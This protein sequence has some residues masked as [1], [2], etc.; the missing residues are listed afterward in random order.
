MFIP[1]GDVN[2]TRTRPFVNYAL[3]GINIAV[4]LALCFPEPSDNVLLKYA[5]IPQL[6]DPKTF[7]TSMFLHANLLHLIGNMLFLWIFGDNIEDQLG[8]VAYLLIYVAFGLAASFAHI[9]TTTDPNV[10]TLG[11]SGAISGVIGAY[12]VFFPSHKI[13]MLMLFYYFV[14]VF[15]VAA[16]WWIGFWIIEQVIFQ[17]MGMP[18]VAYMAHIGGCVA[19][20]VVALVFRFV[21]FSRS[22]RAEA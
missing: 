7:L 19:G 14:R 4:F 18:G 9:W 1:I 2:P 13:R 11:A 22:F 17:W 3:L 15:H 21:F 12:V 6:S 10:P 16:V 5:L 20:I 8:H